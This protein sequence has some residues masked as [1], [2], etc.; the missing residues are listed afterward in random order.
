[1]KSTFTSSFPLKEV[2]IENVTVFYEENFENL[3]DHFSKEKAKYF[4]HLLHEAQTDPKSTYK[5]LLSWKEKVPENP[6]LDNLLTF[7]YLQNKEKEKAEELIISSYHKYPNYLFAKINYADQ[8]LRR[9]KLDEIPKIFPC[10]DLLKLFPKKKKFHVSE[11]R[12]F[13]VLAC[14][15]HRLIKERELA[16]KYYENAYQADPAHPSVTLLEKNSFF[17]TKAYKSLLFFQKFFK[18]ST[19]Q[20]LKLQ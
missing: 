15:Y 4:I 18:L 17:K 19:A 16:K 7:L 8:C 11:Y 10:F 14:R 1:M 13:M 9:K 5:E 12:G 3:L 2:K 20:F 6:L